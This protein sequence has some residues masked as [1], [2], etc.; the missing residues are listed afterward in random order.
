MIVQ[1]N[2][3]EYLILAD[4]PI[5][6]ALDKISK[7]QN[8]FVVIITEEGAVEGV[9]TDGDFRRW[10]ASVNNP[11]LSIPVSTISKK[12][13]FVTSMKNDP[14][15]IAGMFSDEISWLPIVDH[16]NHITAI[17]FAQRLQ[18]RIGEFEIGES[19][20]SFVIAEIGNNHNGDVKMAKRLVYE[21]KHSGANCVKFQMRDMASLYRN[22]G[23]STDI[24]EDLG[25]QYVL[26]TLARFQLCNDK[27]F[28]VFDY[29][30]SIGIMPLCTPWD[31]ASLERLEKYGMEGYKIAS[32]D[33]TNHQLL[34]AAA[35]TSKSVILSTGMSTE[36]EIIAAIEALQQVGGSFALLHCN[37]TYPAPFS[38]IN[39][40]YMD[41]LK[42]IGKCEVGYSGHERGYSVVLA[43]IARGAKVIEKHFTL[44]RSLEG[45][46]HKVSLLPKEFKEMVNS[47][48]DVETSM[49][50]AMERQLTQGEMINR[51]NL[52]KS[53][54]ATCDIAN[55]TLI[56][57]DLVEIKS[58]GQGLQPDRMDDLLGRVCQ[59]KMAKGDFFFASDLQNKLE[60]PRAFFFKRP[61]G[62]PVRYHDFVAMAK[63]VPAQL[64]EFHFSFRDLEENPADHFTTPLEHQ[65]I[66]HAP[67][68]FSGSYLLNLAAKDKDEAQR[69]VKE[70][71]RVVDVTR[72]MKPFFLNAER[73]LIVAN[74]GGFTETS[75][76]DDATRTEMYLRLAENLSKVNTEGVEI[77]PQTMPP[78]PW[79]F[80]GQRH[81]NLFVD[82]DEIVKFC[83]DNNFRVCLDVSHSK[84]ACTHFQR[85]FA[86]FIKTVAP[87]SAH[88]HLADAAGVDDEGLQISEGDIDWS[89]LAEWLDK[90]SPEISFIP[91]IWQG[92]KDTGS[93]FWLALSRLEK[94]L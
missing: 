20:P 21:A 4:E 8:G 25:S 94:W 17:A 80:G 83:T 10:I 57:Q 49:G 34:K 65:L 74:V 45:N 76:V 66:V 38:S 85:S 41:R 69:G 16:N 7:N 26:D 3:Q 86:S 55:G 84:L 6:A 73:P 77:I 5:Q 56:T 39:L 75:F 60:K 15:T 18:L 31:M 91:E 42:N 53:L 40:L 33:L 1:R 87:F 11:D 90:H 68:I 28:D 48:R 36:T 50:R 64:L 62:V 37:S 92:H 30:K 47:I 59:R 46:D 19:F 32:A 82:A 71:Q 35:N 52:A 93:G 61:W 2:I 23:Q 44:D 63:M 9:V 89:E 67:E 14:A 12:Q 43:A 79:L 81:H 88:L 58:P 22:T 29:A 78:F 70:M 13:P 27:M 51:E 24:R 54:T 72:S